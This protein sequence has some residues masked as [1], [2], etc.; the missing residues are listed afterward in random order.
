MTRHLLCIALPI[1]LLIGAVPPQPDVGESIVA[2]GRVTEIHAPRLFTIK[3]TNAPGGELLVLT[4]RALSTPLT[5]TTVEVRGVVGRFTEA[6]LKE[7]P[8]WSEIDDRVRERL[9]GRAVLVATS[10]I[11]TMEGDAPSAGAGAALR[12]QAPAPSRPGQAPTI[13][14]RPATLAGN[15]DWLA[16]R[17]VRI[18]NARVVGVFESRAFL[19]EPATRYDQLPGQR[20]RILVLLDSASLRVSPSLIVAS[21]VTIAGVARTLVGLQVTAE[22]PWPAKLNPDLI[23]RLEV[24]AAILARSVQTAEGVELTDRPPTPER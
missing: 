11:G 16:G 6:E 9:A 7:T 3:G 17:Q 12:A 5:S 19:I 23:E 8:G 21:N 14:L 15:I 13:I 1:G 4:P 24:R 10:L 18:L 22:V 20:D 2:K